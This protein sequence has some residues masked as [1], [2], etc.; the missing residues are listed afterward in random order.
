[1]AG[2]GRGDMSLRLPENFETLKKSGAPA[3]MPEDGPKHGQWDG[4]AHMGGNMFAGGSGGSGTAGLGGRGGPYR[5]DVGQEL[6]TMSQAEKDA[7]DEVSQ[8]KAKAMAEKARAERLAE[9]GFGGAEAA[10]YDKALQAVLLGAREL[11]A[12][13]ADRETRE[14]ERIWRTRQQ[15]GELDDALIADTPRGR[16]NSKFAKMSLRCSGARQRKRVQDV[17]TT[18]AGRRSR[19]REERL[20]QA[21][22]AGYEHRRRPG[23][24]RSRA[25]FE[26]RKTSPPDAPPVRV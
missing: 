13:L 4:K 7:V 17:L 15:V 25:S 3:E 26:K 11:R 20:S 10:A 19:G 14:R 5:L 9:L 6:G 21:S 22:G 24:R 18:R 1:M 8:K 23:G 2:P 16:P 12:A